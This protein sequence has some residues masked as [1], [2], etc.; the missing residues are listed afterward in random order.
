MLRFTLPVLSAALICLSG[1]ALATEAQRAVPAKVVVPGLQ[2]MVIVDQGDEWSTLV[3]DGIAPLTR[4]RIGFSSDRHNATP[5]FDTGSFDFERRSHSGPISGNLARS[6]AELHSAQ[7]IVGITAIVESQTSSHYERQVD[8]RVR[9][10]DD[11]L[12]TIKVTVPCLR[13]DVE[14]RTEVSVLGADGGEAGAWVYT[15]SRRES[16][17]EI[18][19]QRQSIQ[20]LPSTH[21][22]LQQAFTLTIE[23]AARTV[24][25]YW[26]PISIETARDRIT[27]PI[28][29]RADGPIE[30]VKPLL[31]AHKRDRYNARVIYNLG[32]ALELDGRP[33]EASKAYL[34][35]KKLDDRPVYLAAY[36][37]AQHTLQRTQTLAEV[38]GLQVNPIVRPE[39]DTFV[40]RCQSAAKVE[41]GPDQRLVKGCRN[42]RTPLLSAPGK[43][44]IVVTTVPGR[45][46]VSAIYS[47]DGYVYVELPDGHSGF[48]RARRL[49]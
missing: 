34:F 15:R 8:R 22:L 11:E 18:P 21:E 43:H 24:L 47:E 28:L 3:A 19:W 10:D 37:R 41:P 44:G 17:C 31:K 23:P 27:R 20:S 32:V 36:Q 49:R 14:V 7:A 42:R 1:Q 33:L 40:E 46:Q 25:P 9:N 48:M 26:E 13:R 35:A 29:R 39:L 38:Y 5:G 45:T 4:R 30:A 12:E 6:S 16:R 2:R